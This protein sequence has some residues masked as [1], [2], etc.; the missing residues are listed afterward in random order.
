MLRKKD[1][2]LQQ[3]F[4]RL[5]MTKQEW[6]EREQSAS[7]G[8]AKGRHGLLNKLENIRKNDKSAKHEHPANH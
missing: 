3:C 8:Y 1:Q 7:E 4:A 2:S 6:Q 5:S